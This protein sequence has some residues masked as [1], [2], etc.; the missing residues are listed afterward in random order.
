MVNNDW[1]ENGTGMVEVK[2][3]TNNEEHKGD[4]G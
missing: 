4:S 1:F 2:N 3:G